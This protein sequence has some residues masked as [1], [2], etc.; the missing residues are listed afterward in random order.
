MDSSSRE[1]VQFTATASDFA[2]F[3]N[4][5]APEA[6]KSRG[7]PRSD[8]TPAQSRSRSPARAATTVT[9][10]MAKAINVEMEK[11]ELYK[12]QMQQ[13]QQ[14]FEV[15]S[16]LEK[17]YQEKKPKTPPPVKK[18]TPPQKLTK[19]TQDPEDVS[20]VIHDRLCEYESTFGE[21][22]EK[23]H[24]TQNMS[25]EVLNGIEDRYKSQLAKGWQYFLSKKFFLFVLVGNIPK[26]AQALELPLK[27]DAPINLLQNATEKYDEVFAATVMEIAIKYNLFKF[28]PEIRMLM[29]LNDFVQQVHEKN[30]GH[31]QK[32][33]KAPTNKAFDAL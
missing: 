23:I 13:Q 12:A 5:A 2:Q 1:P 19:A 3:S 18:S 20:K 27:L 30:V 31:A 14:E 26:A 22:L 9:P 8:G 15:K 29:L 32:T 16:M 6:K 24:H 17:N 10:E 28:G 21:K 33:A 11:A 4:D 25:P 7:R